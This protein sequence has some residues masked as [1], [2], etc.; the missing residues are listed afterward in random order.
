MNLSVIT[1]IA[2]N[3]FLEAVRQKLFN[4]LVLLSV[5]L[6]IS[7]HTFKAFDFGTSELKFIA[8]FGFGAIYLFGMIIAIASTAQLFFSEIENRTAL[9]IL[10]KPVRRLEFILGKYVGV[11]LVVGIFTALMTTLLAIVL[12]QR[13]TVLLAELEDA[14]IMHRISYTGLAIYGILQ[15]LLFAMT[16]ALAMLVA[17][18]SH[19]QLFTMVVSFMLAIVCQLQHIA[20]EHWNRVES[21]FM[22]GFAWLVSKLFP[23]FQMFNIGDVLI[24]PAKAAQAPLDVPMLFLYAFVYCAAYCGLTVFSFRNREI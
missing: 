5:A 4:F 9:T 16:S 17:S 1:T 15:W 2:K 14:S 6:V 21:S 19:T 11:L 3:T 18:Y 12:W 10:A 13:E 23:S 24:D 20:F 8:D 22:Q 7:S